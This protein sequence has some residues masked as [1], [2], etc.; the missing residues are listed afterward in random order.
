MHVLV[1]HRLS[2]FRSLSVLAA[3]TAL[4]LLTS[5]ARAETP[6]P[7]FQV[8]PQANP[9][10]ASAVCKLPGGDLVTFDGISVDRWTA[11]GAFVGNLATLPSFT[12]P[13]FL[14]PRPDGTEVY[15]AESSNHNIYR[16]ATN[17]SGSSTIVH[18]LLAYAADVAPNGDLLV[19]AQPLGSGSGTDIV[20]VTLSPTVTATSIGVIPGASG[21]VA[22]APNGD[23]YYATA[24]ASF[25]APA[26]STDVLKWTAAQVALGGLTDLNATLFGADFDG[27]GAMDFDPKSGRLFLAET[28]YGLNENR[29]VRVLTDKAHSPVLVDSVASIGS[30]QILEAGGAAT[31]QA[32][33]PSN[34]TNLF[35]STTDFFSVSDIVTL[36]PKRPV[37]TATGAGTTG[38]GAVTLTVTGGVP[39]GTLF[40]FFGPQ[41]SYALTETA[42]NLGSFLLF[43]GFNPTQVRRIQFL[44]PTDANGTGSFTFWN[45]GAMQ[46]QFA[47]Q[48]LVGNAAGAF[49]GASNGILF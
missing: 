34:G 36:K 22:L 11:A 3:S 39:N 14:I 2:R 16:A 48:S 21:P 10:F 37:L 32:Y 42:Y 13:S 49:F 28:N 35:Y 7:G 19:S 4:A 17:G 27:G 26:G 25:P 30:V 33:Q 5:V 31:L 8:A 29:I 41:A 20:R 40:F 47:F 18:L 6:A 43:S 46:G 9:A 44:L 45:P 38:Q 24:A 1:R 23:L 12:F 15:F